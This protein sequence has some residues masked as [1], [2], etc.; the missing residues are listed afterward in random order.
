MDGP[1][2]NVNKIF[3]L[4]DRAPQSAM[5]RP[6]WLFVLMI[7]IPVLLYVPAHWLLQRVLERRGRVL[8]RQAASPR[9][10]EQDWGIRAE[11]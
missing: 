3:G 9:G 1:A 2:G 10:A 7:G 8:E 11:N 6:V 5:P 4:S